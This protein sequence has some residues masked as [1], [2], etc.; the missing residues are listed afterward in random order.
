MAPRADN[1]SE[2]ILILA[3][4][5]RDAAASA[6][7]L[8]QMNLTAV[9]CSDFEQLVQGL[10]EGAGTAIITEEAF[11]RSSYHPLL[12]WIDRQPPW[13]DFPLI[14]LT[15]SRGVSTQFHAAGLM[16]ELRN[17]SLL[18]RPLQA[19]TLL[20][21]IHSCLRARRRQYE[22]RGYLLEREQMAAE[23]ERLVLER[24]RDL[25][26]ANARL[27]VEMA[28]REQAEAALRQKQ[29]ME[30]IGQMTGG[31]AHDFN[32]L[33]TAVLGNIELAA[34]RAADEPTRQLLKNAT[35][36]A[37]RGARL[38][39]Q[40]LAFAR[41]QQLKLEPIDL[42][43]LVSGMGELLFRTIG[44][45]VR[46]ET[47]L[48]QEL[49][50][51]VA[52]PTQVELV[53]LNLALNARDA[54]PTGGRLTVATAN[55]DMKSAPAQG[56]DLPAEDF[57]SISVSDTGTGMTEEVLA[58]VFEP[59]FTTKPLGAGT[60]LGLSQ[61]Y[62]V[63]RQSG[64]G[65]RIETRLGHGTTVWV[66]FPRAGSPAASR[67]TEEAEQLTVRGQGTLLVIDDDPDVRRFVSLV[68]QDLGYG[69][70]AAGSAREASDLLDTGEHIDL[71]LID[72]VMPEVNGAEFAEAL[73]SRHPAPP[74]L[75]FMTGYAETEKLAEHAGPEMIVK[76]PFTAL[77][78]GAAVRAALCSPGR[79]SGN[80]ISLR[81]GRN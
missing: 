33:L 52:D 26:E 27:Q 15:S 25:K 30:A 16:K 71:V 49:W 72:Y 68:L 59:F 76:K 7:M 35:Q 9:I 48:Q 61:V 50:P 36:A 42:N 29:K 17:L 44:A 78:L 41:K 70:L 65:V 34:R 38:T 11:F 51:A 77:Q 43:R 20:S 23:L 1:L 2:R 54:M 67:S 57:V 39:D 8:Q 66:Y 10:E 40:L 75:L 46:I 21:T 62:G 13:S 32:N 4:I 79:A 80:V 28:E 24:T 53:I 19:V 45:T 81:S 47:V 56:V 5:G 14:V 69:V 37:E 12:S 73:K 55:V 31:I 3:P 22:L 58:K 64:G 74:R 60:G 63:A 6:S 18:E